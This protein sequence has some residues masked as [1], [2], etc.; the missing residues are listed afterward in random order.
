VNIIGIDDLITA[1]EAAG[2]PQDKADAKALRRA[3]R[4][5]G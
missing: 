3:L 4:K 1:K 5:G 2:R